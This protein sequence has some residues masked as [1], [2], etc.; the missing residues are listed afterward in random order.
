MCCSSDTLHALSQLVK[1]C[2]CAGAEPAHGE[3]EVIV[4]GGST[5]SPAVFFKGWGMGKPGVPKQLT[6]SNF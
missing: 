3:P 6:V 2:A 5:G 4:A 1:M